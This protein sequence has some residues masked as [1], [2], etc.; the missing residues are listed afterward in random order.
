MSKGFLAG[1]AK[2]PVVRAVCGGVVIAGMA[3]GVHSA[4]VA[5][6]NGG[7]PSCSWPVNV[8]GAATDQQ[9]G[10]VRCYLKAL[11]GRDTASLETV[12]A[13]APGVRITGIPGADW[14]HSADARAGL[15]SAIFTPSPV[16]T[17]YV[18]LEIVYANGKHEKTGILNMIERGGP[19]VWRM[20]IGTSVTNGGARL[21][22][23]SA[24][25]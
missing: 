20:D 1:R 15:A 7:T 6:R 16:D 2:L 9:I 17:S 5:W 4:W 22:V 12:A 21:P 19:S 24:V 3:W 14:V 8:Q 10:L 23:S 13:G 25:P 18:L 11:A